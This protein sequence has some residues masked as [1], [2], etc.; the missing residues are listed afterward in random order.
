MGAVAWAMRQR[1][2]S[3]PRS[4]NRTCGATASGSPTGFIARPT[5]RQFGQALQSQHTAFTMDHVEGELSV[6]AP[7]HL[8][9]SGEESA[10]ALGDVLVH[11]AEGRPTCPIGEVVRPAAQ[12]PVQRV[13]HFFPWFSVA[14]RQQGGDLRLEPLHALLARARTQIPSTFPL[15]RRRYP[16]SALL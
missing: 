11:P 4:S 12:G 15:L 6:A 8:M 13:A 7:M 1:P 2:V 5:A 9:P 16:A 10:H 14:G 3:H